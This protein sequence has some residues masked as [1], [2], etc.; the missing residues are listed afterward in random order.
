MR[1]QRL[2]LSLLPV[3]LTVALLLLAGVLFSGC[4][5]IRQGTAYLGYLSRARPLESL[6]APTG[7]PEE[8]ERNRLF[9]ERV[10]DIRY[11][12]QHELGLN[13]GRSYSR[14]VAVDRDFL[15][16][17]V[18][19]S[20]KDS[21]TTHL[22]RYPIVGAL[23]YRGYF[24]IDGAHRQRERLEARGLDVWIRGV[25]A[26]STLGF[27]ADPV[28]TF[29]RNYRV[30]RLADL[31]IHESLHATVWLR[32]QG[33]FNEEL[34]Q[35]VGVEGARLYIVSRY[36]EDSDEY[37][38]MVAARADSRAFREFIWELIAELEELY[39]SGAEREVI[40]REREIIKAAA[41]E[42]FAAEYDERFLSDNFRGF[43]TMPINNAYLDLFRIY[44]PA[45]GFVENLFERSGMTL[46]EFIA[47]AISMPRR[48]PPGRE[49]LART[50]G[51]WYEMMGIDEP[52]HSASAGGNMAS[53]REQR[54]FAREEREWR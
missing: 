52:A 30:D 23:P 43:S 2:T 53:E 54:E 42:R 33:H 48:G 27:F 36:G 13:V 19:A 3:V 20:A 34:A 41:Q 4:Y 32:G 28:F 9:V 14:Y 17:V 37:R 18:S 50:L 31:I 11:F 6:L 12:A 45:D 25:D 35:L 8:D 39:G 44:T 10:Q 24:N 16:A 26:F 1:D 40:L 47:A 21:F 5:T 29:M 15:V 46:A 51:L 38:A 22:W 49:R 7:D